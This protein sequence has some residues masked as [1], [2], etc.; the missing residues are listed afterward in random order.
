MDEQQPEKPRGRAM[1]LRILLLCLTWL[2]LPVA[3]VI[4]TGELQA[5]LFFTLL[6]LGLWLPFADHVD[7]HL[8]VAVAVGWF[9]YFLISVAFLA[10]PKKRFALAVYVVLL[11]LLCLNIMSCQQMGKGF[12]VGH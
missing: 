7:V 11:G 2:S 9:V 10:V 4:Q 3:L 5:A 6:P 12:S 1:G 8:D